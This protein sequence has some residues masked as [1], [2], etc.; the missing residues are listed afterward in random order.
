MD[1]LETLAAVPI[2]LPPE[3]WARL[4]QTISSIHNIGEKER[5]SYLV[6][7]Y[8]VYC[9]LMLHVCPLIN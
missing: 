9:S 3:Y 8:A 5:G 7:N 1:D 2:V 4:D 6:C